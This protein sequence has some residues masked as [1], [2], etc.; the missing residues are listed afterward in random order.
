MIRSVHAPPL[1]ACLTSTRMHAHTHAHIHSMCIRTPYLQISTL[2]LSVSCT[3][4]GSLIK[5]IHLSL[6]HKK[7]SCTYFWYNCL[8]IYLLSLKN[9]TNRQHASCCLF[10]LIRKCLRSFLIA[11]QW[12]QKHSFHNAHEKYIVLGGFS[13]GQNI[14]AKMCIRQ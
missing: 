2:H 11:N 13:T 6:T 1:H 3:S 12:C 4:Q 5:T 10:D 8:F 9:I 14:D 7:L